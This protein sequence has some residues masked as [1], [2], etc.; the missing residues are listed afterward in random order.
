MIDPGHRM[1]G[2]L[3]TTL[4]LTASDLAADVPPAQSSEV[5]HLISYLENSGCVMI[6]NGKEY[7]GSEGADHVRR[8]YDH[9]RDE[10]DSTESFIEYSATKSL[11]SGRQYQVRCPGE[12]SVS[13]SDWLMAELE[14]YRGR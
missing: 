11:F 13:S 12:E 4:L 10:I 1:R 9:F 3:I 8:K 14:R 6:R 7:E 2:L 5:D